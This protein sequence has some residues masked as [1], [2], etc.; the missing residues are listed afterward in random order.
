MEDALLS[1]L[2]TI[3]METDSFASFRI[4]AI[5]NDDGYAAARLIIDYTPVPLPAG[6][7]LFISV[8]GLR[9]TRRR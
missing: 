7:G 9:F 2:L 6:I 3:R 5:G 8:I 4:A 1:D